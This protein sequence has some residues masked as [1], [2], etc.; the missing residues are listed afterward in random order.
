MNELGIVAIVVIVLLVLS[1]RMAQEYQ[2]AVIFR[3]GRLI[4]ARLSDDSRLFPNQLAV[5]S[6]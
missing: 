6:L 1:V 3:L 5:D 2:R 4:P